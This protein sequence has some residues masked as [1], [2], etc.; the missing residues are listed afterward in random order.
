M[1]MVLAGFLAFVVLGCVGQMV[2]PFEKT[3]KERIVYRDLTQPWPVVIPDDKPLENKG[4][5]EKTNDETRGQEEA[6]AGFEADQKLKP[7]YFINF[8]N[9]SITRFDRD[10]IA[11]FVES[12]EK[13]N[14]ILVIGHSHGKSGVGTLTLASRRAQTIAGHLKSKGFGNVHVMASWGNDSVWFAPGRGVHLYVFRL[15]EIAEKESIPIVF[16]KTINSKGKS[17]ALD[18]QDAIHTAQTNAQGKLG[19]V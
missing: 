10:E 12:E 5:T 1:K 17:D 6:E 15:K 8:A 19:G 3:S 4:H 2:Q 18:I 11:R 7:E 16:A 13:S 9:D 14:Q